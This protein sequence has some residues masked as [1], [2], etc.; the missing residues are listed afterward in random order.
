[1]SGSTKFLNFASLFFI[2]DSVSSKIPQRINIVAIILSLFYA[3]VGA[4]YSK[5]G[6]IQ[7]L[8]VSARE[9]QVIFGGVTHGG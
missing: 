8:Q 4:T 9:S 6:F 5:M 7:G 3:T 1:M 2:I